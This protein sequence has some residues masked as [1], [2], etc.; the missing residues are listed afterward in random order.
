MTLNEPLNQMDQIETPLI[1]SDI[2]NQS[3]IEKENQRFTKHSALVTLL[4]M[5]IGPFSLIVQAIGEV[6]DMKMITK[7]F[8][9]DPDSR[10]VEIL[11]F[12]GQVGNILGYIGTYFGLSLTTRISSLIGSGDRSTASH[13]VSDVF[14][15]T[16]LVSTIFAAVFV[17]IIQPFLKFLGTPDYMLAPTFR[18]LIPTL[19][20]LPIT[21]IATIGQYYLQSIGNSILSGCVKVFCYVLQLGIFSPLFLF[22]F[23]V[24]TTFMKIG[25]I[26]AG[27]ITAIIMTILMYRNK[28]SLH[29]QIGDIFD[30]FSSELP[31]ALLFS[32]P[33]ILSFVVFVL[34]PI[35]ILQTMTSTDKEHS[36]QIGGVFAVFTTIG[37]VNQAIPGAFGQSLLSAG[38]HAWGS[39]NPKR[40]IHLF[41]WTLLFNSCL[42]LLV[43]IV[44]IPGKSFI[45]KSFLADPMELEL[46]NKMIP[47][48]FYTSPLQGIGV[49]LSMLMIIVGK[50]LFSF[51]PQ[52]VQML[53]LCAGCKILAAK[54]KDDVTKIMYVYNISDV[55][56]FIL[57]CVFLFI[58]IREI[59][60]KI[61]NP[62]AHT[63]VEGAQKLFSNF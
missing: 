21:N 48:P 47:I 24:S 19:V 61:N 9:K 8:E 54:N 26:I 16:I 63:E 39:N 33:L 12:S 38:T 20:M 11:G 2:N 31:R 13:L 1:S 15:L 6:L 43:S 29:L 17:F 23:K 50:P 7:S 4:L 35:L 57:Y 3:D 5:S 41:F 56:V 46:A 45:C 55:C 32:V 62:D 60:K 58:P 53:I 37:T 18:Y 25:S 44:V 14:Y 34:P 30:K 49:T 51:I 42:T 27:I 10:A 52:I 36:E 28:F 59:K 40:L 22:G